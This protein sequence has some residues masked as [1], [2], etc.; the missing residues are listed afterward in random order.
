MVTKRARWWIGASVVLLTV[1]LMP[2]LATAQQAP[3]ITVTPSTGLVDGQTVTVEGTG[4]APT[5]TFGSLTV[6]PCPADIL[7]DVTQA[8]FRCGATAA[9][10][11]PVDGSGTFVTQLQVFRSQPTFAGGNTLTCA[12]AECVMLAL[13]VAGSPSSPEVIVA[14]APISFRPETIQDCKR[15]G[16][17]NLAD[18]EG[19]PFRNQGGC[20]SFVRTSGAS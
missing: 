7:I 11:V 8:P 18:G 2:G 4:F 15:E 14:T 17:R 13:E 3:S 20:V 10:P 16:W 12:A 6:G 19:R 9:F 5:T 1:T